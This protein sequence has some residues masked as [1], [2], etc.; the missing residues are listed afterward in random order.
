MAAMPAESSTNDAT[1]T[2]ANQPTPV[3]LVTGASAG[4]GCAAAKRLAASGVR[5]A[6]VARNQERLDEAATRICDSHPDVGPILTIPTDVADSAQAEAAVRQTV[7]QLGRLDI[8]VN[9]AGLAPLKPIEQTS[10]TDYRDAIAVNLLGPAAIVATAWPVFREQFER[11]AA[12]NAGAERSSARVVNVT[13]LGTADPFPGFAAYAAAKAALGSLTR[14]IT[15][16]GV[17]LGVRA[18]NVAPGAVETDMLRGLF[19]TS[20]VPEHIC[21]TPDQVAQVIAGCALGLYDQHAGKT[22]YLTRSDDGEL[23]TRLADA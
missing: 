5:L 16:E 6:M 10:P 12:G 7:E 22:L 14:S 18:F 4:I 20:T 3:A 1:P 23:E 2:A 21:L 8:V 19:N 11:A 17:D 15:N 9:N 13:T